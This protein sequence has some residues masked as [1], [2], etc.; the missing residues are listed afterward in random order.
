MQTHQSLSS[1]A[2]IIL[3]F[4]FLISI[5][6]IVVFVG[7]GPQKKCKNP[8]HERWNRG[9]ERE[10][11]GVEIAKYVRKDFRNAFA[12]LGVHRT[13]SICTNCLRMAPMRRE[14]TQHFNNVAERKVQVCTKEVV[15]L[16]R[17]FSREYENTFL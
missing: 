8:F 14:F 1:L 2:A 4:L 13:A 16:N 9:S 7:H 12:R 3:A 5:I 11:T 10:K 17:S 6:V 15:F